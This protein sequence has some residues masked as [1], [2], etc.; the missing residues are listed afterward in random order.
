MKSYADSVSLCDHSQLLKCMNITILAYIPHE[1]NN[2]HEK[3]NNFKK[4][5]NR[6]NTT[7]TDTLHIIRE[8]PVCTPLRELP[9]Q[10]WPEEVYRNP[11]HPVLHQMQETG[12]RH[13]DDTAVPALPV[14]D[15]THNE[16]DDNKYKSMSDQIPAGYRLCEQDPADGLVDQVRQQCSERDKPVIKMTSDGWN[17]KAC[18]KEDTEC[19]PEV[20]ENKHYFFSSTCIL[21]NVCFSD[22]YKCGDI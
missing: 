18:K 3:P 11:P 15:I 21:I 20:T 22:K 10:D 12:S 7:D 14:E 4:E 2:K 13:L 1:H 9:S 16:Y 19:N 17:R 8:I 5:R 6:F